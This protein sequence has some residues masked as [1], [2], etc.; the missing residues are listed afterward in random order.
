M[1]NI[2]CHA[3]DI[4]EATVAPC[5]GSGFLKGLKYCDG[6]YTA[7]L[8]PAWHFAHGVSDRDAVRTSLSASCWSDQSFSPSSIFYYFAQLG[9]FFYL[10]V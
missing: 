4:P 9:V 5:L 8:S 7:S 2:V 10:M 3:F 1:E 6:S